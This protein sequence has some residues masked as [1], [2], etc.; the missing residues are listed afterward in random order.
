MTSKLSTV[1]HVMEEFASNTGLS[2]SSQPRRYLWTDAFA[3][4]NY[5]GLQKRTKE[6]KYGQLAL[7]LVNSVH[8]VLGRHRP[9][10]HR[11]VSQLLNHLPHY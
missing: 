6:E 5:L 1:I 7:D 2:S 4:C 11:K 3:V 10:D 9:D 8:E